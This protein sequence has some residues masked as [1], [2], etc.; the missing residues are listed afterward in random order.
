MQIIERS[1]IGKYNHFMATNILKYAI[2]N[3]IFT[4]IIICLILLNM[5]DLLN[6]DAF[7]DKLSIMILFIPNI[8]FIEILTAKKT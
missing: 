8:S 5:L 4:I 7:I 6:V 1:I 2:T 3:I